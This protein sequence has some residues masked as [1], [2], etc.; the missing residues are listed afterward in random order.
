MSSSI[1]ETESRDPRCKLA[2]NI[3]AN[4]IGFRYRLS[5][6][7]GLTRAGSILLTWAVFRPAIVMTFIGIYTRVASVLVS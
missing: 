2:V 4:A 5:L 7:W 6:M 1:R 3:D